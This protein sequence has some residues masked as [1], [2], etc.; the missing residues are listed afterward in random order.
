M[1][2]SSFLEFCFKLPCRPMTEEET[3]LFVRL[4]LADM[5]GATFVKAGN[6]WVFA[7]AKK[8]ATYMG[9][10]PTDSSLL[11]LCSYFQGIGQIALQLHLIESKLDGEPLS[12]KS[13]AKVFP[14]GFFTAQSSHD[15]WQLNKTYRGN[16]IDELLLSFAPVA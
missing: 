1:T 12:M 7:A 3:E 5:N 11:F 15:A 2:K 16:Y 10:N 14:D 8:R 4:T 13:L 9:M 6:N